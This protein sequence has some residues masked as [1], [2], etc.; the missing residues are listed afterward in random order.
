[1]FIKVT[2]T[3]VEIRVKPIKKLSGKNTQTFN[4]KAGGCVVFII[5]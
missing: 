4:D 1:M 3:F 5:H 2:V